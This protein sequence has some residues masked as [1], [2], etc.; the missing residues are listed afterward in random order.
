MND[1]GYDRKYEIKRVEGDIPH[2]VNKATLTTDALESK[3]IRDLIA[4]GVYK[5]DDLDVSG[6]F[7]DNFTNSYGE[8]VDADDVW[9]GYEYRVFLP[10][11]SEST[12]LLI[13]KK[14]TN[15]N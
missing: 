1:L 9:C 4:R 13:E 3:R 10:V 7:K 15:L 11:N 6:A 2:N 14:K 8:I 12:N 5:I